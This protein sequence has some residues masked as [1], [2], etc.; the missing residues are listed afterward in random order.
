MIKTERLRRVANNRSLIIGLDR[1][2]VQVSVSALFASRDALA[3]TPL[4]LELPLSD[5][6]SGRDKPVW[7]Q[8]ELD[9]SAISVFFTRDRSLG[10]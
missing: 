4:F 1:W 8:F 9:G 6:D 5:T 10:G 3:K 7:A 2:A